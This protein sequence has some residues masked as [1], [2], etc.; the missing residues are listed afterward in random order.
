MCQNG[1]TVYID[2]YIVI[3]LSLVNSASHWASGYVT[4]TASEHEDYLLDPSGVLSPC[5]LSPRP[6]VFHALF[7]PQINAGLWEPVCFPA[8]SSMPSD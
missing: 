3:Y 8:Q 1:L 7:V 2:F 4:V 5:C 6:Y